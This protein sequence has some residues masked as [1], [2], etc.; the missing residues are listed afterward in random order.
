MPIK[1]YWIYAVYNRKKDK[2]YI[3]QTDNIER[4]LLEHNNKDNPRHKFTRRYKGDWTLFYQEECS[5]RIE[6]LKREKQLKNF[7]GR[8]FIKDKLN[9]PV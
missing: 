4:R 7:K 5:S 1:M 9:I 2:I 8:E 6:A 3:G